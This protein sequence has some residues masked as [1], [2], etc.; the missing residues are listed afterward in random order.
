VA[1]VLLHP[2]VGVDADLA[3]VGQQAGPPGCEPLVEQVAG[4]PGAQPVADRLLQPGLGDHHAEQHRDHRDEHAERAGEARHVA[5]ADRVVEG[6]HAGVEPDLPLG[7]GA[8]HGGGTG[9]Q[10]AQP[11]PLP[12]ADERTKERAELGGDASRAAIRL[13][14]ARHHAQQPG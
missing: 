9:H 4:E 8:D 3:G 12:R 5:A 1:S 13:S 2:L 11:A 6:A 10:E 7:V 14:L